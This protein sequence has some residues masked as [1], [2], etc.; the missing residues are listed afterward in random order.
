M[1]VRKLRYLL[2]MMILLACHQED[3]VSIKAWESNTSLTGEE[4]ILLNSHL[5]GDSLT[6]VGI[7]SIYIVDTSSTQPLTGFA[8]TN[9][10]SLSAKP[11]MSDHLVISLG[12]NNGRPQLFINSN[13]Y[14]KCYRGQDNRIQEILDL[15]IVDSIH[16][17]END[18][19]ETSN[20]TGPVGVFNDNDQLLVPVRK[21]DVPGQLVFCLIDMNI[22]PASYPSMNSCRA[23]DYQL[24]TITFDVEATQWVRG[25]FAFGENFF[26]Q[27]D[28]GLWKITPTGDKVK[29]VSESGDIYNVHNI[30]RYQDHLI[31]A[32]L[33]GGKIY[34]SDLS[35]E[36]WNLLGNTG[37][38]DF[39]TEFFYVD[40]SL[41]YNTG[42]HLFTFNM[43][44][45]KSRELDN[46]GLE[47]NGIT[48]VN[49]FNGKV[50]VTT[51]SGL[52]TR[53]EKDFFT[54]KKTKP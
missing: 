36:D 8:V 22:K 21:N 23:I 5:S 9:P 31:A 43:Q 29:A 49:S 40:D 32:T 16:Y 1:Q 34:Q 12:P 28:N 3:S 47:G 39:D 24:T 30:F 14:W 50:W 38:F 48:S 27:I 51:L 10:Y 17:S 35:G 33:Y 44:T 37:D 25:M 54:Y 46:T 4:K 19:I 53:D 45:L 2:P 18:V 41:C 42:S 52:F 20:Y 6:I 11:A 13:N 15:A 26:V 7:N